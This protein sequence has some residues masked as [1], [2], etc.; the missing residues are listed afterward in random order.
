MKSINLQRAN[1]LLESFSRSKVVPSPSS[2]A[3]QEEFVWRYQDECRAP[4]ELE[5]LL[6]TVLGNQ[7]Q[8]E[9]LD[10]LLSNNGVPARE[11][12]ILAVVPQLIG[13]GRDGTPPT[14]ML[15]FK[16]GASPHD[17]IKGLLHSH[18]VRAAL[19]EGSSTAVAE[20]ASVVVQETFEAVEEDM[21]VLWRGLKDHG[22]A[23]TQFFFATSS[24][25]KQ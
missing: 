20:S 8:R 7:F 2:V 6:S 4:L 11:N 24:T 13:G 3:Q 5:P 25:I 21:P 18:H 15:W 16:H 9:E 1:L 10:A 22:W 12:Y 19:A 14:T 17:Q 23:T